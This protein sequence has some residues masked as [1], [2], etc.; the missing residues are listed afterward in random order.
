MGEAR[1]RRWF[2][3]DGGYLWKFKGKE[4]EFGVCCV[5]HISRRDMLLAKQ[6]KISFQ[7]FCTPVKDMAKVFNEG[8]F[9]PL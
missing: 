6:L 9:F 2:P 4:R 1:L 5:N 8:P 7:E 3:G